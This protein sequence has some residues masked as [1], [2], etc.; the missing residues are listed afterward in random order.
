MSTP[1]ILVSLGSGVASKIS[2]QFQRDSGIIRERENGGLSARM[3]I[4]DVWSDRQDLDS[5]HQES[6][7]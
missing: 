5:S 1:S 2:Y 6:D 3:F 7:R 4:I